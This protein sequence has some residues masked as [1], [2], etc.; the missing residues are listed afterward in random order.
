YN[1]DIDE[2]NEVQDEYK[3]F[4]N[5]VKECDALL[6]V[7]PEYKRSVPSVLKN[8]LDVGS[9]PKTYSVSNN[10]PAAIISMSLSNSS[11]FGVNHH[12]RQSLVFFNMP[13]LQQP[14]AYLANV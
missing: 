6:F 3:A 4:G 1:Q 8:A 2:Y 5:K 7:T 11:G 10:I 13:V 14:E 12:L 9:R